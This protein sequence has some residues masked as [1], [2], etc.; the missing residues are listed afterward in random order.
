MCKALC[1]ALRGKYKRDQDIAPWETRNLILWKESAL[2]VAVVAAFISNVML[3]NLLDLPAD[4]F[5]IETQLGF[6]YH[7]NC[8]TYEDLEKDKA[9]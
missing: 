8:M 4:G 2:Y 9:T 1:S 7:S 3:D 5:P 6:Q